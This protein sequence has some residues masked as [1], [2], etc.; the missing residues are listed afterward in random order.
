MVVVIFAAFYYTP[1]FREKNV[2]NDKVVI[3]YYF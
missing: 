2:A 1:I 3:L